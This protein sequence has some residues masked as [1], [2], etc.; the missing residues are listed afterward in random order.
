M[1][2]TTD[3][4]QAVSD[5]YSRAATA[6]LDE[7]CCP[8]DYEPRYLEAIPQEILERDYGCGDP[9]RFV[10]PGETVLDLGC[11]GGKACYI[12]SQVVGPKG[13][14]IGVDMN[15]EMLALAESHREAIGNRLGY[16]N[17]SFCR[18]RIQDLA[19]DPRRLERYLAENPVS[20]EVGLAVLEEWK[21]AQRREHPLIASSS[22]DVIVSNC[23]LNLVRPEDKH[24]LF[25]E[26]YRVLRNG[27]RAVISDIVC[28]KEV[29]ERMRTDP[30]LWSGCISG[31]FREDRFL[32]AFERAGFH[33]MKIL[34]RGAEPWQT[35]EGIEF[36]SITVQAFRGQVAGCC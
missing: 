12:A 19:L 11:G 27:G 8:V 9:T 30:E 3:L 23:V 13:R 33:G 29:P 7:L 17:G 36:R 25:D 14:V 26:M 4:E 34:R 15:D 16:H 2:N 21:A 5:R 20:D 10:R 24:E 31:A 1:S 28:D 32:E 22:I 6:R 35:I 18:G